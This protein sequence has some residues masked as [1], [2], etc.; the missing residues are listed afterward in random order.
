M[1]K[2]QNIKTTPHPKT[3]II[4]IQAPYN[5]TKTLK[6]IT[7]SFAIFLKPAALNMMK[8]DISN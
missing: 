5:K 7:K 1:A 3:L 4:G 2:P 6:H 8:N